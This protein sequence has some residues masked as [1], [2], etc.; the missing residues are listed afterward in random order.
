MLSWEEL[1]SRYSPGIAGDLSQNGV[2]ESQSRVARLQLSISSTFA[3]GKEL[4]SCGSRSLKCIPRRFPCW[5]ERRPG[6]LAPVQT[7]AF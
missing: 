4:V 7:A 3:S 6:S 1:G 5:R 2:S